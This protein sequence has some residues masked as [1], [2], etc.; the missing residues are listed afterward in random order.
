MLFPLLTICL[1]LDAA[2]S[3]SAVAGLGADG[4]CVN[5]CS[6]VA[7]GARLEWREITANATIALTTILEI[8]NTDEGTTRT[9]TIVNE[10]P[11]GTVLPQTNEDGTRVDTLTYEKQGQELSTLV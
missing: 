8:V 5:N 7:Y 3:Q 1:F 4:N 6:F 10:P 11:P 2:R 9:T